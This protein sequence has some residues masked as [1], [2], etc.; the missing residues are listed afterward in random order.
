LIEI[1]ASNTYLSDEGLKELI[2][3]KDLKRLSIGG[4]KVSKVGLAE[5]A[6]CKN[7]KFLSLSNMHPLGNEEI[8]CVAKIPSLDQITLNKTDASPLLI[9]TLCKNHMSLKRVQI[10]ECE[11]IGPT[12]VKLLRM[13]FPKKTFNYE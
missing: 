5:L 6:R 4:S 13:E 9:R 1:D 3:L 7:L 11:K 12:E 10:S 2:K 8:E